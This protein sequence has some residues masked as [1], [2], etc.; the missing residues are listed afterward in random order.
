MQVET[1]PS[2]KP[3][4][5]PE[6]ERRGL[7]LVH[8]GDG[9][10]KTSASLGEGMASLFLGKK[11]IDDD[12]LDDLETRLLTADVGVEATT[13]IIGNL[14]KRVARKELADSGALYKALQEELVTLLKDEHD[15]GHGHANAIVAHTLAEDG[16][17]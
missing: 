17:K 3:Y 5:K 15:M 11:A 1:P 8:T 12:L 10:G 13:A 14:T 16:L 6:G 9:K 2:E 4:E 7:V